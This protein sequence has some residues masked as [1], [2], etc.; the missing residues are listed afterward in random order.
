MSSHHYVTDAQKSALII[1]NGAECSMALLHSLL[2]WCPMVVVLDGAYDRVAKLGIKIDVVI[3]DFDSIADLKPLPDIDYIKIPDQD[4]TDLE[5]GIEYLESK[6]CNDISVSW[7]TGNRLDHTFNNMSL[8]AKYPQLNIVFYDDHSKAYRI[9]SGFKK[10]FNKG[11]IISLLPMG[12]V[13]GIKTTNLKYPLN[14]EDLELGV[15]SGSSNEA[16]KNGIVEI[17]Y[18][19]GN[20]IL[21]ESKD[22]N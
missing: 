12:K 4:T 17:A 6:G 15:R 22:A 1:A 5:K 20:L 19:A 13:K 16:E 14:D 2:E 8:L 21:V 10:S 11:D 9:P 3:G 7:V 18:Q